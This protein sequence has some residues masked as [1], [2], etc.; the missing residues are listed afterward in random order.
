MKKDQYFQDT[1]K[2]PPKQKAHIQPFDQK[3][4]REAFYVSPTG[5]PTYNKASIEGA[6]PKEKEAKRLKVLHLGRKFS[7]CSA[8]FFQRERRKA[9]KEERQKQ[10]QAQMSGSA[11]STPAV[12]SIST[13]RA[14]GTPGPV[15]RNLTGTPL[16]KPKPLNRPS[17]HPGTI[18]GRA[19]PAPTSTPIVPTTKPSQTNGAI[20]AT[21]SPVATA[22]E[23]RGVKRELD[24]QPLFQSQLPTPDSSMLNGQPRPPKKRRLVCFFLSVMIS[25]IQL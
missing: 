17:P 1:L 3:T 9:E 19:T 6:D 4:L 24:S 14:V 7:I 10:Q 22:P 16:A 12:T 15:A 21:P 23:Q 8:L 20:M 18:P 11:A 5:L 13:P 25:L 2:A